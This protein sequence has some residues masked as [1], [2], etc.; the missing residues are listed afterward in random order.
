[1][2]T[3]IMGITNVILDKGR[4]VIIAPRQ[5]RKPIHKGGFSPFI[6]MEEKTDEVI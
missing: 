4:W 1:M 2:I 6:D 3:A 5:K